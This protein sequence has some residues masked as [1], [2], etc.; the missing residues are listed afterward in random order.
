MRYDRQKG[1]L[2]FVILGIFIGAV[3][4][5]TTHEAKISPTQTTH[6]WSK[7]DSKAYARAQLHKEVTRQ[8]KCL[9][10]MWTKESRWNPRAQSKIKVMGRY[11]G[12]IPQVLGLS[13]TSKPTHQIDRGLDYIY[14]RYTTP[15]K[16]WE[17]WKRHGWY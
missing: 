15:C 14:H 1:I 17:W 8:M 3:S 7:A 4:M 6:A 10:V 11:A 13:P 5:G 9:N 12:G 2:L 16:A